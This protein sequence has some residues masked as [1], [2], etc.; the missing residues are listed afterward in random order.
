MHPI[1]IQF[2]PITIYSY[3]VMMAIAFLTALYLIIA[4]AR[5]RKIPENTVYDL[6]LHLV[7]GGIIG[8][9][10][11]Y[12]LMNLEFFIAHPIEIFMLQH[13][14]LVFYGGA[15]GGLFSGALYLRIKKIDFLI[16]RI[17]LPLMSCWPMRLAELA[18][19]LMAAVTGLI[20]IR[21]R[22]MRVF[23]WWCFSF[24]SGLPEKKEHLMVRFFF[25][26]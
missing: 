23:I 7:L 22:F 9:R 19:I 10:I 15:L 21:S 18:V 20:I 4:E 13:G 1:F 14:G 26:G 2:G 5:V 25:P 8:A 12:I 3:G 24:F 11:F 16:W 17:Y 6:A